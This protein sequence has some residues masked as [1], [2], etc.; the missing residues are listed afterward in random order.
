MKR[1]K[2][3]WVLPV[4]FAALTLGCWFGKPKDASLTERR[5]LAQMPKISWNSLLSGS[6]ASNFESYTQDQ[7]PLR[8]EFRRAKALFSVKLLGRQD[9]NGI[10]ESREGSFAQLEYPLNEASVDYAAKRFVTVVPEIDMPGHC[11]AVL[12]AHPEFSTTPREGKRTALTWGIYNRQN[13]V[14]AP[15]PEVFSFLD[16]VFNE[17]CALFPSKYIHAG[18]DECAPKWWNESAV[19][20]EFM[21]KH[22]LP[23]AHALQTHFMHHVQRIIN[24][25]GKTMLGWSGG[26]EG[27]NPE[28]S[29]LHNWHSWDKMPKSRIDSTHQWINSGST[30]LYFTSSEDS[31][32]SEINPGRWPRSVKK[33]YDFELVPDSAS[34]QAAQNLMGVEGCCW[35]EYCPTTWKVELQVFP[36]MAALAEK[37]WTGKNDDWEGFTRRLTHQLDLYDLWGIRYNDVVERTLIAPRQ[38]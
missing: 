16:D 11:M 18:G 25:H 10:Y 8:E 31:T 21:K 24:A 28:G 19:A 13:N 23:D 17:V 32:Q 2:L 34:V 33:V 9:N 29:V 4:L 7:F 20:Q 26:A 35:T 5:K 38:R 3:F 6:F 30:G 37:A 1:Q 27:M 12:A 36:R 14:L 22:N 15:T